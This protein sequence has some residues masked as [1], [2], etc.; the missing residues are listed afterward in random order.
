MER[1]KM[2]NKHEQIYLNE[3]LEYISI[4]KEKYKERF[5]N[6]ENGKRKFNFCAAI[7]NV[8]WLAFQFMFWEW[9]ILFILH[10]VL[11]V[12]LNLLSIWFYDQQSIQ[13]FFDIVTVLFNVFSFLFL[14]FYG[15]ELLLKSI[16]RK[17][18]FQKKMNEQYNWIK[19]V[20]KYEKIMIFRVLATVLSFGLYVL[21]VG[22]LALEVYMEILY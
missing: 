20:Y 21:I 13:I 3:V 9:G 5:Y 15:D 16:R 8:F 18:A 12:G 10:F 17:I 22:Q 2:K 1:V 11:Q 7:F 19:R 14:G 4:N 6:L